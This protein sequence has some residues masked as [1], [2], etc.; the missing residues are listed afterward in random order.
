MFVNY[1]VIKIARNIQSSQFKDQVTGS[2]VPF[3]E[4]VKNHRIIKIAYLTES[5]DHGQIRK[6]V[7]E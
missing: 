2:E 5:D 7:T 6:S 1:L 4:F 3:T